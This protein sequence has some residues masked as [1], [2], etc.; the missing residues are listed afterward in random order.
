MESASSTSQWPLGVC[1]TPLPPRLVKTDTGDPPDRPVMRSAL[2][3]APA[4]RAMS[5]PSSRWSAAMS[6]R[7]PVATT[8]DRSS[9]GRSASCDTRWTPSARLGAALA[10]VRSWD[11]SS[12]KLPTSSND[13]APIS[14]LT[15]CSDTCAAPLNRSCV[16]VSPEV[17]MCS[18][19]AD[20]ATL[21][22][23][24]SISAS[25]IVCAPAASSCRL[26][27]VGARM[28]PVMYRSPPDSSRRLLPA[29][30]SI[31]TAPDPIRMA[32]LLPGAWTSPRMSMDA[33]PSATRRVPSSPMRTPV[34][35]RKPSSAPTSSTLPWMLRL[36]SDPSPAG[37]PSAT[38]TRSRLLRPMSTPPASST[39]DW[40]GGVD[41]LPEMRSCS[42]A[43][44]P[45]SDTTTP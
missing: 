10:P 12:S 19:S 5:P 32:K 44:R 31:S 11:K 26:P 22:G 24:P 38:P 29:D 42:L 41:T 25:S 8:V 21:A 30:A 36:G 4:Y 16:P 20:S 40:A 2:S 39:P 7:P 17:P 15:A 33:P 3:V 43:A 37:A 45:L 34:R 23:A 28:R 13:W 14:K 1:S 27:P 35:S 6:R 18:V 9:A